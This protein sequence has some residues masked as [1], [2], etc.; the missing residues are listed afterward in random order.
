VAEE[1]WSAPVVLVGRSKSGVDAITGRDG[2]HALVW[3]GVASIA[4][5]AI[6]WAPTRRTT[7]AAHEGPRSQAIVAA[8]TFALWFRAAALL[9]AH[10]P[11]DRAVVL[12]NLSVVV[13]NGL[14][15]ALLEPPQLGLNLSRRLTG[16]HPGPPLLLAT[17]VPFGRRM[18]AL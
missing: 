18:T 12:V 9:V 8:L 11:P 1:R 14:S 7:A 10:C 16:R 15:L 6:T 5:K 4:R 17:C 2:G 13:A 3:S